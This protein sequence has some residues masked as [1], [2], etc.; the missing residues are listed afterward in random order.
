M[1]NLESMRIQSL[2]QIISDVLTNLRRIFGLAWQMDKRVTI[3]YYLTAMIG[4]LAPLAASITLAFLIDSLIKPETSLLTIPIIVVVVLAARYVL[5]LAENIILWGLNRTYFDYL[6]RYKVQNEINRRFYHKLSSLDIAHLEDPKTQNL[7]SKVRDTMTWRPPDFLRMFSYFFG[8]LISYIAAFV[9]LIPFGIW[10][11]LLITAITL[12]RL[13]LR[14]K[15]GTIQWSIYGSGAP[16]V[17]RLWYLTYLLSAP[18]AIREM[19]IF[20][21]HDTLLAKLKDIQEFL[22]NLNKKPLDNYLRQLI[23]PPILE[24]IV[25]FVIAYIQLPHVFSAAITVGSFTLLINMI[26]QLNGSVASAV[27]NFGEMYEHNLYVDDYFKVLALPKIITEIKNPTVIK[28]GPPQIEFRNVSFKY[29]DGQMVLKDI[30]FTIKSGESVALVGANGA[31]KSTIIKL[32]CRFYD[33]TEGEILINGINI[34]DIK[35]SSWY[36]CTGTL[37]QDFVHYYLTVKDNILLGDPNKFDEK[38][39]REAAKKA[40]A[41]EFIEKLPKGFDQTLGR[42]YEEGEELSIGQWQKLAIAR[43]FYQSPPLL[44]LDEPTSAIDAETEYEIFNNLEKEYQRKT[45]ILVSHRFSTVRN[46]SDILVIENGKVTE[47]GTHNQ[48]L[49]L[50]GKYAKMFK[51][52]AEGYK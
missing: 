37:F 18:E 15:Y 9:V 31:G 8:S 39:M 42:E 3:G 13:Y 24:T 34:K 50:N 52:Q 19:R 4:A 30:S 22:F 45:L 38:L 1:Y 46:A 5:N 16:Q 2:L 35:L 6:F 51:T 7:I 14:A 32:I 48:L 28:Y 21:S 10:I 36:K 43:A 44:I 11:P 29:P 49:K 33:V 41:L 17:R 26:D 47:R 20:Q 12:P 27:V 25:L 40:G 23:Y